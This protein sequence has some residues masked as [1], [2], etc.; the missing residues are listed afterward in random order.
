VARIQHGWPEPM[1]IRA[2]LYTAILLTILGP[3]ATTAVALHGMGEMG[4]SFDAVDARAR[5]ESLA[6]ELKFGVTDMNG[7][8]TAYGYDDGRSR[9][10][11][12]RSAAELRRNLEQAA[13]IFTQP[14]ERSL[15]GSLQSGFDRFMALD[16]VAWRALQ[17]G[18]LQ[19]TKAILLGPELVR[20]EAM[21][22][23]AERLASYEAQLAEDAN[24]AFSDARDT[25]RRRMIA[26]A[27]GAALVIILLLFT[28]NDVAR[29]ALEEERRTRPTTAREPEGGQGS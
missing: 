14:R 22:A 7:W 8:Q 28:A 4:D 25:A 20:F 3:L 5:D 27:L 13:G 11:F 23:A 15:L 10:R 12:V 9:P 6:R 1:T 17:A 29:M 16:V 26:V 18:D 2:K 24:R 21:A 19:R